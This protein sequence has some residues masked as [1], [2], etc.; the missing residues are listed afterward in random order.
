MAAGGAGARPGNAGERMEL[1][2][3][4]GQVVDRIGESLASGD[5]GAGEV[6]R[7]EDV[8]AR[9]GVSRTVAR[10]A[11]RVLE[12]KHV[13]TSRP[14]VGITVLPMNAWNLYDPQVIRWRLASPHREA[15][16]RE[17]A[18]LRTAV[19]PYAAYLAA[20]SA[21]PEAR[22]ELSAHAESM[23]SSAREGS[24]S[25]FIAADAA[26]HRVL[27]EASGNGMFAQLAVVTE[28]L[29]VSRGDLA[30]MPHRVDMTAVARHA[31]VA[32]AVRSGQSDEAAAHLREI[33]TSAHGEVKQIIAD[34]APT[35][36]M[37]AP[38]ACAFHS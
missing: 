33:I 21:A 10:E 24:M 28:E 15:Q 29:L 34:E 13:V 35:A 8:Q 6:L 4:H 22:R 18:E 11:V 20:A 32:D 17:L 27:L 3:L 26:F 31:Q 7:L 16:L 2:G 9:F 14:R 30:L 1:R 25:E 5:I 19:E 23:A 12:S 38:T 37:P 36:G